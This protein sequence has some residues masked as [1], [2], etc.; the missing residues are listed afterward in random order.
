MSA[1]ENPVRRSDTGPMM[2]AQTRRQTMRVMVLVKATD[3]SE[4][5]IFPTTEQWEAMHRFNE[6]LVN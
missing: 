2:S 5:G 1:S 6:E 3:D 4:K